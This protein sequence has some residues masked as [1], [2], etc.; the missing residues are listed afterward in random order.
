VTRTATILIVDDDPNLL[1][2]FKRS[3]NGKYRVLTAQGAQAALEFAEKECIHCIALDV[4]LSKDYNDRKGF[5]LAIKL[6]KIPKFFLTWLDDGASFKI[7]HSAA[8]RDEANVVDY[9][10][11]SEGDQAILKTIEK[12]VKGLNLDLIIH[13]GK[14]TSLMLVEMLKHFRSKSE[15]EKRV[16]AEELEALICSAFKTA[17]EVTVVEVK[18]GKGGCVVVQIEPLL[19]HG[20]GARVMVKLG[21]RA[22]IMEEHRNYTKWVKF[23]LQNETTQVLE[24]PTETFHLAAIK[25]SFVGGSNPKGSF[26]DFFVESD[27]HEVESLIAHL[28]E[29]TCQKWYEAG[30]APTPEEGLPLDHIFRSHESLNLA[31]NKHVGELEK[32]VAQL[33]AFKSYATKVKTAGPAVIEVRLGAISERLPNPMA[34]AFR[35]HWSNGSQA[36]LFPSPLRLA[37][38]HGDLNG[39]NIVVNDHGRGF[40]IDFY[41]TGLSPTCRDFVEL[42]SIIKFELLDISDL[43][44]R[45][46]LECALLA[47]ARLSDPIVVPDEFAKDDKV[48]KVFNAIQQLRSL[49]VSASDSDDPTEYYI[50]LLF[51]ALKEIIGFSSGHDDPTCCKPRQFHAFLS[52]AKICQRLIPDQTKDHDAGSP[53]LIFLNYA[54]EDLADVNTIYKRLASEGY[55][56]WMAKHDI[57]P[58]DEWLAAVEEALEKAHTI[59]VVLSKL[60]VEKRGYKQYEINV[61]MKLRMQKLSRDR[62]VIPVLIGPVSE[63][64]RDFKDLQVAR[65]YENDG[66]DR[67]LSSLRDSVA[68]RSK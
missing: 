14:H 9:V 18:Q 67:L 4:I 11:K 8:M 50:G 3:L 20:T 61:A 42:E 15:S 7:G 51:N 17:R 16:I 35:E 43:G 28:F 32:T 65:L 31:D 29:N 64:P 56:P 30:R 23:Y 39:E 46:R 13:W 63:I 21:P 2:S 52:A 36:E 58:G 45:Y 44:Q 22:T 55:K 10:V 40:L 38:T 26:N 25:Y 47:P 19:E 27:T 41:K 5:E 37:I 49:A 62:H 33:L 24:E 57:A 6:G 53:P 54:E 12:I 48:V 1:R 68:R 60:S 59:I 66:W 34:Y